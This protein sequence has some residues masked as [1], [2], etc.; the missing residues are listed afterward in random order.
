MFDYDNQTTALLLITLL[1]W[2]H[3]VCI[4]QIPNGKCIHNYI[5]CTNGVTLTN[6]CQKCFHG[7]S[8]LKAYNVHVSIEIIVSFNNIHDI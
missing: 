2:I 4:F 3:F 1:P 5:L 6:I 7:C 8:V